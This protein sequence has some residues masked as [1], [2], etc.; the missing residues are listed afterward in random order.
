MP[1]SLV[2]AVGLIFFAIGQLGLGL[3]HSPW[4]VFVVLLLYDGFAAC[5]D[6]V[7]KAWISTLLRDH[8][9]GSAQGRA[10]PAPPSWSRVCGPGSPGA[11]AGTFH[12]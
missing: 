2:F 11:P 9:Q 4:P 12:Y 10:P 8:R 7:G 6:G 5:T 1:R 3:I